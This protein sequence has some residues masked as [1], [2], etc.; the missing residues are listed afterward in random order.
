MAQL[1]DVEQQLQKVLNEVLNEDRDPKETL[2]QTFKKAIKAGLTI[3]ISSVMLNVVNYFE[4]QLQYM[5]KEYKDNT[6]GL[7]EMLEI[8]KDIGLTPAMSRLV[9]EVQKRF[10]QVTLL[11]VGGIMPIF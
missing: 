3:D 8:A 6:T 1:R 9:Q 4:S 2:I 5:F 10:R 11:P 7:K